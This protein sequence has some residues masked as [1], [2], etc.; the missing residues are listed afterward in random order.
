MFK[1]PLKGVMEGKNLSP[2][3]AAHL[4]QDGGGADVVEQD[5]VED[6]VHAISKVVHDGLGGGTVFLC[7]EGKGQR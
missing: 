1:V 3:W 7:G 6:P 2:L 5:R 4:L